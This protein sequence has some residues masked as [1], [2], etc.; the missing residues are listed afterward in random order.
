M[1]SALNKALSLLTNTSST[2]IKAP[3]PLV[4]MMSALNKTPRPPG[5][6]RRTNPL[7]S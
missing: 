1:L 3:R 5:K 2:L 7:G 4:T 6:T